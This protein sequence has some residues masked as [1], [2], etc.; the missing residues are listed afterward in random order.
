MQSAEVPVPEK[1]SVLFVDSKEIT[2]RTGCK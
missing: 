1:L 2:Q